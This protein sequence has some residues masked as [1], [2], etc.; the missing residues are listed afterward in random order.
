MSVSV[1]KFNAML[2]T[3]VYKV[4]DLLMQFFLGKKMSRVK[5]TASIFAVLTIV[6]FILINSWLN[7]AEEILKKYVQKP[8]SKDKSVMLSDL[9]FAVFNQD[10]E[11]IFTCILGT[12][13]NQI[14][15]LR[16]ENIPLDSSE[17]SAINTINHFLKSTQFRSNEGSWNILLLNKKNEVDVIKIRN[18]N[19]FFDIGNEGVQYCQP[20]K[21]SAFKKITIDHS[22]HE[23]EITLTLINTFTE[24]KNR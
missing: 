2:T 22:V 17:L 4:K 15:I 24:N 3:L 6:A 13:Q 14:K 20:Y 19:A 1:E 21:N 7:P 11:Y 9:V 10:R 5:K 8:D 23:F 16:D 18:K 12:Y